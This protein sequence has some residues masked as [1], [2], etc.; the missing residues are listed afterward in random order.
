M[1]TRDER[2]ET[3]YYRDLYARGEDHVRA[4]WR[5]PFEQE[6]RFVMACE[7]PWSKKSGGAVLDLGCGP[8]G[9]AGH[10]SRR[11]WFGKGVD[12][13]HYYVGVDRMERAIERAR[14]QWPGHTFL[15]ADFTLG[16]CVV[17]PAE[18]AMA[19]GALVSG[20]PCAA[21]AR[22]SRV[23]DH[24][25]RVM[26]L[27]MRQGVAILLEQGWLERSGVPGL[28]PALFGVREG[29]ELERVCAWLE[30]RFG[31]ETKVRRGGLRSDVVIYWQAR[32]ERALDTLFH[33]DDEAL[34]EEVF[35]ALDPHEEE[36]YWRGWLYAMVGL[37]ARANALLER[38]CREETETHLRQRATILLERLAQP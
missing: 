30:D 7:L 12:S 3:E 5:H 31:V 6:A 28:E 36:L 32:Q 4:G 19:I 14:E 15:C 26:T 8:G 24:L 38:A 9:L 37:E 18:T 17:K 34:C 22:V 33:H 29:E 16:P 20:E 35:D 1:S 23:R 10:L 27:S 11:E 21:A 25:V 13:K 2:F